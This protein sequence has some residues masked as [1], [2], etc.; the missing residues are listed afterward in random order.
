MTA[1]SP[2]FIQAWLIATRPKTLWAG[3]SPVMIG[4]AMAYAAG[5]LH[6]PVAILCLAGAV[7]VQIGTNFAN[8]YFDFVKGTD[9]CE[10]IGPLRATQAGLISP[11]TM[12][13]AFCLVMGLVGMIGVSL[14][15]RAGWPVLMIATLSIIAGLLYTGGPFPYG[16][17]GLG[18]LFVLIFFGP[19]AVGGTYY[20]QTLEI[21]NT[22][23]IA[24][25]APGLIST[26]ILAVNNIRDI[27]E[28]G[29]AGKNTLAVIF[30]LRF[31]RLEYFILLLIAGLIPVILFING[32]GN[33]F[34]MSA[35]VTLLLAIPT[36]KTLYSNPD[37][38]TLN[39]ILA[40]TG[41]MLLLFSLSFSIGW[42]M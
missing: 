30:G 23:I 18:D 1:N 40:K 28:D 38:P 4:T 16:Y 3:I 31:A 12:K 20:V 27:S 41:L 37:G 36:I 35:S 26:A 34:S 33:F 7:L 9:T 17:H 6:F 11:Q 13:R 42:L 25:L 5:G 24:G 32:H 2:S 21:N 14:Y 22:V 10:R 15:F 19:V 29:Q 8:D 39:K